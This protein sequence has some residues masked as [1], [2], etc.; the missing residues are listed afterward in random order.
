MTE[1]K[2]VFR[3]SKLPH[4]QK[5]GSSKLPRTSIRKEKNDKVLAQ[6]FRKH[7]LKM[8]IAIIS[9]LYVLSNRKHVDNLL[10]L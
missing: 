5:C 4:V 10:S 1:R 8:K 6:N 7:K 2:K 3:W 9:Y